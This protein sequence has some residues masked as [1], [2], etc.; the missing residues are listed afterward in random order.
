MN[1]LLRFCTDSFQA[2]VQYSDVVSAQTAKFVSIFSQTYILKNRDPQLE[3]KLDE[4]IC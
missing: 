4:K 3:S 1:S 2:L